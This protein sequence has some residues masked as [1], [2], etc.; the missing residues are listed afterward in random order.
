M[1]WPER[2]RWTH[3]AFSSWKAQQNAVNFHLRLRFCRGLSVRTTSWNISYCGWIGFPQ[4]WV[5]HKVSKYEQSGKVP[6]LIGNPSGREQASSQT[7][8]LLATFTYFRACT[9]RVT[10][11]GTGQILP[12]CSALVRLHTVQKRK[13]RCREENR[14]HCHSVCLQEVLK[15]YLQA[16]L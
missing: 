2:P 11:G 1:A 5:P 8:D 13:G 3:I 4:L 10:V 9:A 15:Y 7:W 12:T 16:V 6:Y 14:D